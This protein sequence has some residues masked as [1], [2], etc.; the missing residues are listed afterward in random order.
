MKNKQKDQL[1]LREQIAMAHFKR[2]YSP[3]FELMNEIMDIINKHNDD[4]HTDLVDVA[5]N[6][7]AEMAP[8]V[9]ERRTAVI[10]KMML[11]ELSK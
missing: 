7:Y 5:S 3:S 8:H 10:F 1:S 4:T 9:K 2:R 6:H 11:D